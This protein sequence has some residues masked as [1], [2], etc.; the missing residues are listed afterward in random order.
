L[1]W[2]DWQESGFS[3]PEDVFTF[4]LL[5]KKFYNFFTFNATC[6]DNSTINCISFQ[7]KKGSF[8]STLTLVANFFKINFRAYGKFKFCYLLSIT[9]TR[10]EKL[11]VAQQVKKSQSLMESGGT[12]TSSQEPATGPCN[13]PDESGPHYPPYFHFSIILHL[14]LVLPG[15]FF[16]S[17]P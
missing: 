13:K 9:L 15:G 5:L 14:C 12:L 2:C 1:C 8:P 10:F 11:V 6:K 3:R 17:G 16:S 7:Y 4:N